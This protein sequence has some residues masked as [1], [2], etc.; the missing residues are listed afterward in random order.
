[1]HTVKEIVDNLVSQ[2]SQVIL[3]K[4]LHIQLALTCLLAR[5]QSKMCRA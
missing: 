1:M 4:E 3:G 2:V 5:G